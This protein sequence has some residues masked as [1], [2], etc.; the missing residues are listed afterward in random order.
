[1]RRAGLSRLYI[2]RILEAPELISATDLSAPP[3]GT[4]DVAA[5]R[6][7]PCVLAARRAKVDALNAAHR[8]AAAPGE[9]PRETIVTAE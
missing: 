4:I 5:L 7:A 2:K 6:M 9:T 1:M 3:A 8:A